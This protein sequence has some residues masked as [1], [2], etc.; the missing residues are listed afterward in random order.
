M[1]DA[2]AP[3]HVCREGEP[4][5]RSA[6]TINL[7]PEARGGPFVFW[8][9]L[10]AACRKASELGFDAIEVFPRGAPL[11]DAHEL[12]RCLRDYGL[13]LAAM[14]TG[15][16]WVL[17]HYSLTDPDGV[18]QRHAREFIRAVIDLAGSFGAPAIVGSM[19]GRHHP[20]D[21]YYSSNALVVPRAGGFLPASVHE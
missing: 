20:R 13:K 5:I 8:D 10:E 16:G 2:I 1:K 18:V 12:R 4:L 3:L 19:Q 6:V 14:G 7:V 21:K 15:A 9:D 11:F 17:H